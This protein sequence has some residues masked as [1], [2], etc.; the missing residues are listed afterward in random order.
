MEINGLMDENTEDS[1]RH[2][3]MDAGDHQEMCTRI[4]KMKPGRTHVHAHYAM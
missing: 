2:P 3:H 1:V 4:L